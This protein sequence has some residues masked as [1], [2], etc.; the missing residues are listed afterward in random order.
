MTLNLL[1]IFV[2]ELVEQIFRQLILKLGLLAGRIIACQR[3]LDGGAP[4][5]DLVGRV[6][7]PQIFKLLKVLKK[8]FLH[9]SEFSLID[10]VS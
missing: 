8:K 3:I 7:G 6:L 4:L 2:F 9:L 10:E 5:V 1:K